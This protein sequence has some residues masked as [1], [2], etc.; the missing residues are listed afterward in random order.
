MI[1]P[2]FDRI[3]EA[4]APG[5][6]VAMHQVF[7][8]GFVNRDLARLERIDFALVVVHTHHVMADF[9]ETSAGDKADI[10]RTNYTEIHF[11]NFVGQLRRQGRAKGRD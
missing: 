9:G 4:Q 11:K 10:A 3:G 5:R 2:V 7:E 1:N 6:H 8:T